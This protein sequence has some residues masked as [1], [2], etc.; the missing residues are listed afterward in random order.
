[1]AAVPYQADKSDLLRSSFDRQQEGSELAAAV[2]VYAHIEYIPES[3]HLVVQK[4]VGDSGFVQFSCKGPHPVLEYRVQ[5]DS[6]GLVLQDGAA[7]GLKGGRVG[8][9][10]VIGKQTQIASFRN[11]FVQPPVD[12]FPVFTLPEGGEQAGYGPF[13]P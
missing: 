5:D 2:W 10:I 7:L 13:P 4:G 12:K 3:V 11:S 1:M 6:G 8:L 9:V